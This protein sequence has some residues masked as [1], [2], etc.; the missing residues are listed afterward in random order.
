LRV[1]D[2]KPGGAFS[3]RVGDESDLFTV[4]REGERAAMEK[5]VGKFPR[6]NLALVAV[7]QIFDV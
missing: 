4:G 7:F 3:A 5:Y 1:G 6:Q 2:K